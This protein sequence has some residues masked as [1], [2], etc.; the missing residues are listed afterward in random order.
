MS[1]P[2]AFIPPLDP[3]IYSAQVRVLG[4]PAR[5]GTVTY[6]TGF[7]NSTTPPGVLEFARWIYVGTTGNLAYTKWD[8]TT[9]TLPNLAAGIWHPIYAV[10]VL[11]VGTTVAAN[12]LRWGS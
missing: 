4:G 6:D 3:N 5:T 8:G 10:N 7:T 9:E 12:Q 11:S 2:T 1:L